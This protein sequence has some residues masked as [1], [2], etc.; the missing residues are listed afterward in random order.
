MT[1]GEVSGNFM[2]IERIA[3]SRKKGRIGARTDLR[4]KTGENEQMF[5]IALYCAKV[6]RGYGDFVKML[7]KGLTVDV[8]CGKIKVIGF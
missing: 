6:R 2:A 1:Y 5:A 8:I 7:W 4:P 3:S